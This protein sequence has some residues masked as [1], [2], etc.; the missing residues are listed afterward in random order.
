MK[1]FVLYKNYRTCR[2][3]LDQLNRIFRGW[4]E[5]EECLLKWDGDAQGARGEDGVCRIR[6]MPYRVW[7]KDRAYKA[8]V[9]EIQNLRRE[10]GSL[11]VLVRT[12]YPEFPMLC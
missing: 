5:R 1:R 3:V 8:A 10:F 9:D 4:N 11:C 2:N 6:R 7:S 12:N